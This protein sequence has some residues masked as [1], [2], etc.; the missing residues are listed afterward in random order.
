MDK[1]PVHAN[2]T[3]ISNL[4]T[5]PSGRFLVTNGSAIVARPLQ[6]SDLPAIAITDTFVVSSQAAMLAL[7][8]AERGDVAVRTDLNKSFILLKEI[9]PSS[10]LSDWQELLT[11]TDAVLS[12]DGR[13]GVVSLSDKYPAP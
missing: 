13:T 6:N 4:S 12:V 1:Q 7:S 3:S 11:P 2:L 10:K 8:A 9:T 5:T